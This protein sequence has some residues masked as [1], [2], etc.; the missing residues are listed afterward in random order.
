MLSMRAFSELLESHRA[1]ISCLS[2][3]SA[4]ILFTW[5]WDCRNLRE[6]RGAGNHSQR[7][8]QARAYLVVEDAV[9]LY[10]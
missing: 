8:Q 10:V 6:G 7:Q 4:F 1:N 9:S 5:G 3:V 2:A